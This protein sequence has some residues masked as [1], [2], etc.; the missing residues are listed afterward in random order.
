M[1]VTERS[2]HGAA[3]SAGMLTSSYETHVQL[4][5]RN[6]Q[7][8]A[9]ERSIVVNAKGYVQHIEGNA[10]VRHMVKTVKADD[11]VHVSSGG[12]V[13]SEMRQQPSRTCTL[14]TCLPMF[15]MWRGG[16][17]CVCFIFGSP[18]FQLTRHHRGQEPAGHPTRASPHLPAS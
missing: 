17:G 12:L 13:L 15:R 10:A 9:D 7:Q 2:V 1:S 6:Q 5:T 3:I 8:Y 11:F 18:S 16:V 4:L 14:P